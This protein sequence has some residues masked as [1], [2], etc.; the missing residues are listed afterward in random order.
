M[1][2]SYELV[3]IPSNPGTERLRVEILIGFTIVE[4]IDIHSPS[5]SGGLL[6]VPMANYAGQTI[7][8]RFRRVAGS[9][10]GGTT[11]RIEKAHL[12][13]MTTWP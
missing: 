4:T 5:S 7:T 11:F 6:T 10:P 9:A 3:V 8:L 2:V 1:E 12:F 13:A